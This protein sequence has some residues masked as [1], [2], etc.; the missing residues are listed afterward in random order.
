VQ[1]SLE[2]LQ[3]DHGDALLLHWGSDA[4]PHV[5]V[6]DGGPSGI[7]RNVLGPRLLE[8][9][10]ERGGTLDVD[11]VMIS[12]IDDDH[13]NGI[14]ALF[15]DLTKKSPPPVNVKRLW[16]NSFD[17]LAQGDPDAGFVGLA[18]SEPLSVGDLAERA[19]P[20][21]ERIVA[22]VG[23]GNRVIAFAAQLGININNPPFNGLIVRKQ[24]PRGRSFA[25]L[26]LTVLGPSQAR[27]DALQDMWGSSH[28]A[29]LSNAALAYID[30]S[31][32]N[33]SSLIMLI[34][35]GRK[36]MLLTGDARGD[37]ILEGLRAAGLLKRRLHL[38]LLKLPHHGSDRNVETDFFR[39][40]TAD[41]YVVSGNGKYHNP[42][43]ATLEMLTEARRGDEFKIHLT[44]R[45]SRIASWFTRN[46]SRADKY[47]VD[48]RPPNESSLL[49]TIG[50]R[51][52]V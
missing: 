7:Y 26:E 8:L 9:A 18:E 46:K 5:M 36:R 32:P 38:D 27:V 33:L 24:N 22:S 19:G 43:V 16:F 11:A 51:G 29:R 52:T 3:A 10:E 42:E 45:E 48:Y 14:E 2:A 35:A 44:N 21:T 49:V 13:I 37:D 25:G 17:R 39:T 12:H 50:T 40:V 4:D 31:V 30:D 6:I 47:S 20:H 41:H 1:F 34:A 15:K 23:Q 28:G